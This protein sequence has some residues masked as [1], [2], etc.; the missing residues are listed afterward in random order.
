MIIPLQ[1]ESSCLEIVMGPIP[2][3]L[4]GKADYIKIKI[5]LIGWASA[6]K[7]IAD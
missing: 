1:N 4:L 3:R 5:N 7:V 2:L 6:N